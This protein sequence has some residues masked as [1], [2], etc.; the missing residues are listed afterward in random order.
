MIGGSF[1]HNTRMQQE[2]L[3]HMAVDLGLNNHVQ[4]LGIKHPSEVA[5][6]M[7]ESALVILP[8][9]AES[10]GSVL[11]EALS[12]G[13]PVISTLC[14]GPEDIVKTDVGVLVPVGNNFALANAIETVLER[15]EMYLSNKLR[16]YA[17]ERFSWDTIAAQN[18]DLYYEAIQQY[19][20]Q[21]S[22]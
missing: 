8:S 7:R 13:T 1:Y 18:I 10:F 14:G 17:I 22:L 3:M 20:T 12:C 21:N 15:E 11:V 9:R 5:R 16:N 6:Y 19:K 2:K 4:F